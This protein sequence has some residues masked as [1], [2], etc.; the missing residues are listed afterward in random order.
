MMQERRQWRMLTW[1]KGMRK[2]TQRSTGRKMQWGNGASSVQN[3]ATVLSQEN[4]QRIMWNFII[5]PQAT[6][7]AVTVTISQKPGEQGFL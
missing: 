2:S 6:I 5:F 1:K 3:A 4:V 7:H